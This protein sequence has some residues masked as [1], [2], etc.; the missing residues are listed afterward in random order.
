MVNAY[1][2]YI[3]VGGRLAKSLYFSHKFSYLRMY[4]D[5][6]EYIEASHNNK[7]VLNATMGIVM[8]KNQANDI[9]GYFKTLQVILLKT[10][11]SDRIIKH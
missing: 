7:G 6:T 8:L 3:T 10:A 1:I 9:R 11:N 2:V 5:T 4:Q